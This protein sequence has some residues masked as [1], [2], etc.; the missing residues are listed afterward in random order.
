M[1]RFLKPP[2]DAIAFKDEIFD[3]SLTMRQKVTQLTKDSN[4]M[5]CHATINPL[6]FSLENY[7]A[8]GRWRT[9]EKDKPID[10]VSEY[11]TIDGEIIQIKGARDLASHAS[12]NRDA[13]LGFVRQMFQ[14]AVKQPPAAYGPDTL[15]RLH[16][17]F[18]KSG[19]HIRNLLV[20]IAVTAAQFK[21]SPPAPKPPPPAEATASSPHPRRFF[22]D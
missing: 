15:T 11:T 7:D 1:G 5:G 6:G 4:C 16:D 22:G 2:P 18:A 20:E 19:F 3:P 21:L 12:G 8:V 17:S 9:T 10:P 13:Q 14:H